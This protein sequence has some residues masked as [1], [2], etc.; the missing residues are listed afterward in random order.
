MMASFCQLDGV[1]SLCSDPGC[2]QELWVVYTCGSLAG[3]LS[4]S[5]L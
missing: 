2:R 5:A 3:S 4:Q 1:Q